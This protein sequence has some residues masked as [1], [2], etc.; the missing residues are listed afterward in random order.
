MLYYGVCDFSITLHNEGCASVH[1]ASEQ[2]VGH[3][4]LSRV[5]Y[6]STYT[7]CF[8]T[9]THYC[10]TLLQHTNA[11]HCC[12]TLLQH[13]AATHC[14]NTLLQHT[15]ATRGISLIYHISRH[16]CNTLLQHTA[17]THC[18]CNTLLQHTAATRGISLIHHISIP[19]PC[20]VC[21]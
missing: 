8:F 3:Q 6:F 21:N 20:P 18:C 11:R 13:T 19:G 10:S 5:P 1:S 17:A 4:N 9:A 16:C 7:L 14:C 15:A 12:N 2:A